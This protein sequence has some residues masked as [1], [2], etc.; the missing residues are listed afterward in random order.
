LE[1]ILEGRNPE[2][3]I[4]V[5]NAGV[6][7]YETYNEAVYFRR[8]GHT[9]N[10]DLV[11]IGY[12]PVNDVHDKKSRFERRAREKAEHPV[13]YAFRKFPSEHLYSY[14]YLDF[15]RSRLKRSYREWRYSQPVLDAGPEELDDRYDVEWTSLYRDDFEGWRVV[16]ESLAEIAEL[17]EE[18]DSQVLLA[19]FPDLRSLIHYRTSLRDQYFPMLEEAAQVHGI[20]VVDIAEAFKAFEGSEEKVSLG[21]TK[22]S[23]HPNGEGCRVIAESIAAAIEERGW[24]E[25]LR[26]NE[27]SR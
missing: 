12:Y 25:T 20:E 19:V 18:I 24:L 7:G 4:Q 26:G 16:K 2:R 11:V 5:L 13:W 6:S 1:E 17:A 23:T 10:P 9:F 8:S 15:M 27:S 14:Q 22:G 21:E 3:P